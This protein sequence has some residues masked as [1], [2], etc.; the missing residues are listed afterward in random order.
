MKNE[1]NHLSSVDRLFRQSLGEYSPAPP[2]T[3]WKKIKVRTGKGGNGYMNLLKSPVVLSVVSAVIVGVTAWIIY[4][5]HSAVRQNTV[6]QVHSNVVAVAES[7]SPSNRAPLTG[8]NAKAGQSASEK[9]IF[10]RQAHSQ[11]LLNKQI[12]T[13]ASA[14]RPSVNVKEGKP[15]VGQ[16]G[17][18]TG[19]FT[20]GNVPEAFTEETSRQNGEITVSS[21][22]VMPVHQNPGADTNAE[23][24][25]V[26]AVSRPVTVAPQ[27]KTDTIKDQLQGKLNETPLPGITAE[28]SGAQSSP[29][30]NP[31]KRKLGFMTGLTGS[32]GSILQQGRSPMYCYEGEID[33]GIWLPSVKGSLSTGIGLQHYNDEGKFSFEY[34]TLDTLGYHTDTTWYF[35][36]SVPSYIITTNVITDSSLHTSEMVSGFT[37]KYIHIPLYFD[38]Q[39]FESGR[40]SLNLKAGPSVSLLIAKSEPVP[41]FVPPTGKLKNMTNMSYERL[42]TSWQLVIAPGMQYKLGQNFVL[43]AAPSF[44]WFINNLY[45]EK[46]R[47]SSMPWGISISGGIYY[48]FR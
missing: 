31:V 41:L 29:A 21:R 15:E 4:Q 1:Q 3:V 47:P 18:N 11:S 24:N 20:S 10:S 30:A 40:L 48:L 33:A 42:K 19:G 22:E 26:E 43:G 13:A 35:Q 37:Y 32:Y 9:E 14:G 12:S 36:D 45:S 8:T 17:E 2:V 16:N 23:G 6:N 44:T 46:A 38:W 7:T 34:Q 27:N 28:P 25:N 5:S 39:V